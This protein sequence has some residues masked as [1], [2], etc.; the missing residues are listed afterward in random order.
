LLDNN[1]IAKYA[2]NMNGE[3]LK[4]PTDP[5]QQRYDALIYAKLKLQSVTIDLGLP[6]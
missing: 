3:K 1:T 5:L 2:K 6:P 4:Q